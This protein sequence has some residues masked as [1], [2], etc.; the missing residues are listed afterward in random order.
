MDIFG[1][2]GSICLALCAIPQAWLC[3]KQGH[4]EGISI[5]FLLL[6]TFGEIFTLVYVIYNIDIPLILNYVA[7]LLFLSVIWKY[8]FYP[9]K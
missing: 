6:W 1:Y 8:R 3:Y 4:S 2:I 5:Y 7:N 9:R